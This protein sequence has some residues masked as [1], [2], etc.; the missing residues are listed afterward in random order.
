M[1]D[2]IIHVWALSFLTF[3]LRFSNSLLEVPVGEDIRDLK[4]QQERQKNNRFKN[5]NNNFACASRFFVHDYDVKM[6][7]FTFYRGSIQATTKFPLSFW[8][9][10]WFLG[11]QL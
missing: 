6:T 7:Y 8:T 1:M 5:L 10:I 3:Q 2:T 11:I 9:G 4:I